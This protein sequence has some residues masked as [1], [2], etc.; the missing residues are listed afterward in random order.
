MKYIILLILLTLGVWAQEIGVPYVDTREVVAQSAVLSPD[1][2][3]FYTYANNTLTHWSLNPVKVLESVKIEDKN[4]INESSVNIYTTLDPNKIVFF[5]LKR[6][7]AIYD[8]QKREFIVKYNSPIW[9][10]EIVGSNIIT[11]DKNRIITQLDS[12]NLQ[13]KKQIQLPKKQ[14]HCDGCSDS[15]YGIFKSSDEKTFTLVTS[16]RFV[17][18]DSNT[19]DVL[20][21]MV[22]FNKDF[23]FSLTKRILVGQ[24]ASFNIDSFENV[25]PMISMAKNPSLFV[26]DAQWTSR[27]IVNGMAL[28]Y[29]S[30]LNSYTFYNM[31]SSQLLANLYLFPNNAWIVMTPNGYF[32]RSE[33]SLKYFK[34]KLSS[35]GT[36]STS[37][38][39]IRTP[40]TLDI[41]DDLTYQ[42][43]HKQI[44]IVQ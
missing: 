27:S 30:S 21:E 28:A 16:V 31:K 26:N 38:G 44:S 24:K 15:P 1:G 18:M 7:I 29:D 11:I 14:L 36:F 35:G 8:I 32:D 6:A 33:D 17:I 40:L 5:R 9:Y 34:K 22:S 23:S 4:F 42:K 10:T 13:I 41:I 37:D 39:M 12:S 25:S 3:T 2:E 19:L 43:Y 20:K